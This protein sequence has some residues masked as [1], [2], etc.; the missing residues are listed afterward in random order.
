MF[1]F[2]SLFLKEWGAQILMKY[3]P[4]TSTKPQLQFIM[5]CQTS[6]SCRKLILFIFKAS[7]NLHKGI[8]LNLRQHIA[9]LAD[10]TWKC[11][12]FWMVPLAIVQVTGK[13]QEAKFLRYV[14]KQDL[15]T[16]GKV[17][18][19]NEVSEY[20]HLADKSEINCL[21]GSQDNFLNQ[22]FLDSLLK[23]W[24]KKK[25]F[26]WDT[27]CKIQIYS[28]KQRGIKLHNLLGN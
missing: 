8:I 11:I 10:C 3:P 20:G 7:L 28:T 26:A 19:L 2:L 18:E 9:R 4:P 14:R 23:G 25:G 16:A 15:D 24:R 17:V 1:L 12:L 21:K 5:T 13:G 27:D 6:H 22:C